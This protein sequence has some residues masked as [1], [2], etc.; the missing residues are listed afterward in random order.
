MAVGYNKEQTPYKGSAIFLH[1]MDG[2]GTGGC[3]AI[4]E[5]A[6]VKVLQNVSGQAYILIDDGVNL[7]NY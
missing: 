5:E 1:C 7:A 2:P 4:P 3:I 6:M